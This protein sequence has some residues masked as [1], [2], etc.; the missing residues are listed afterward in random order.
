MRS[1]GGNA[2]GT[3]GEPARRYRRGAHLRRGA[4]APR[5]RGSSGRHPRPAAAG[6]GPPR[7]PGTR[8]P[9]GRRRSRRSAGVCGGPR[10][11]SPGLWGADGDDGCGTSAGT[12]PQAAGRASASAVLYGPQHRRAAAD[13]HRRR[14]PAVPRPNARRTA[15]LQLP[16]GLRRPTPPPRSHNPPG[17]RRAGAPP[18]YRQGGGAPA[19]RLRP[20][21]SP[22]P[23]R[24]PAPTCQRTLPEAGGP[25]TAQAPLAPPRLRSRCLKCPGVTFCSAG[26]ASR[27]GSRW[28][29]TRFFSSR[30]AREMFGSPGR[31]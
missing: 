18:S 27:L 23:D 21:R 31:G 10:S 16:Q 11:P 14:V 3:R 30:A 25:D 26:L 29:R 24:A 20:R 8:G 12:P 19:T 17:A 22:A 15:T 6:S 1:K 7:A 2:E 4:A 9:G 28:P 13:G 5:T